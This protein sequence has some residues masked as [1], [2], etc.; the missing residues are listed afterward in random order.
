M[1]F[2]QNIITPIV[3]PAAFRDEISICKHEANVLKDR[4]KVRFQFPYGGKNRPLGSCRIREG[5][6]PFRNFSVPQFLKLTLLLQKFFQ[7]YSLCPL[8]QVTEMLF[9]DGSRTSPLVAFPPHPNPPP[10][11]GR[12]G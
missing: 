4:K 7:K 8:I 6:I 3:C 1:I 12:D 2:F 5:M 9:I 10:R 11:R